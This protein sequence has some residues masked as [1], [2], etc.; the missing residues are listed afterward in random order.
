M[1]NIIVR[2]SMSF[3]ISLKSLFL[4]WLCKQALSFK[5]DL[6]FTFAFKVI[7]FYVCK[8]I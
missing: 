4:I 2:L 3:K 1:Y 6:L 8:C 7:E 5:F